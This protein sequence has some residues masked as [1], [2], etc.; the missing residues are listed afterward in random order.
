MDEVGYVLA[1]IL[2]LWPGLGM[3][4]LPYSLGMLVAHLAARR[5][6]RFSGWLL[7][8]LLYVAFIAFYVFWAAM[9]N[10]T[11]NPSP[12]IFS[13]SL[14]C[15]AVQA[16]FWVTS[17]RR[18]S[19]DGEMR[20]RYL[21]AAAGG[22]ASVGLFVLALGGMIDNAGERERLGNLATQLNQQH[23]QL[24]NAVNLQAYP[25]ATYGG[26]SQTPVINMQGSSS[27]GV[28]YIVA[29]MNTDA[30]PADV[31]EFHRK[32]AAAAGL[33]CR[34]GHINNASPVILV[35]ADDS[36]GVALVVAQSVGNSYNI[37]IYEHT[38]SGYLD[39]LVQVHH[40]TE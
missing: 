6:G 14:I 16:W 35:A 34:T 31:I 4:L 9:A 39:Q 30:A 27:D 23:Q 10:D 18:L 32:N 11:L 28:K 29:H 20:D 21:A 19:G 12:F 7:L 25:A 3:W 24:M 40:L 33:T 5:I 2:G 26:G 13:L 36:R 17:A 22:I 37:M 15:F 8:Q 1:R 38:P